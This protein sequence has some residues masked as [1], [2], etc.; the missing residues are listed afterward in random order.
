MTHSAEPQRGGQVAASWTRPPGEPAPYRL[1]TRATDMMHGWLDGRR[2]IPRVPAGGNPRVPAGGMEAARPAIASAAA[3][4][5]PEPGDSSGPTEPGDSS[6]P[7]VRPAE[8]GSVWTP[9]IEVLVRRSRE[10]IEGERIRFADDWLILVR[11]SVGYQQSLDP[12]AAEVTALGD[13]LGPARARPTSA[14]LGRRRLAEQDPAERPESLVSARRLA[15]WERQLRAVEQEHQSATARLAAATHA[16]RLQEDLIRERAEVARAAA[17]R[18]HELQLRRVATYLQQLLRSHPRGVE[19][20]EW[21]TA[22]RVG[23]DLPEWA[24]DSTPIESAIKQMLAKDG[25]PGNAH[26]SGGRDESSG[27]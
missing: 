12:L 3:G 10:L 11:R 23:P 18:H 8:H 4:D 2:G 25:G 14:E 13:K 1:R 21:L 19:L 7:T 24:K 17:R 9:R 15:D 20:N 27:Q 6:G 5:A 26:D 16:F 22:Y